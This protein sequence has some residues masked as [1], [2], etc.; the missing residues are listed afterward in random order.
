[1]SGYQL[2]DSGDGLKLEQFG[3]KLLVRPS[4]LC[5]WRPREDREIWGATDA[6][7]DHKTGW[8][9]HTKRFD[10]WE[11]EINDLAL[12]LRL[13]SNGQ[14]GLFPEHLFV[15]PILEKYLSQK[16]DSTVLNLY[17]YTG[18]ASLL[19]LRYGAQV[20]HVDI[21]KNVLTWAKKNQEAS[22]LH[23]YQLRLIP[24]DAVKFASREEKRGNGYDII[25]AD[26]PS[27]TRG[28]DSKG[29]LLEESLL[30]LIEILG[31][32]LNKG[33]TLIL[34]SHRH[35]LSAEILANLVYDGIP[36]IVSLEERNLVLHEKSSP[37]KIP[38]G[39][40]V[41]ATVA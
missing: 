30:P 8:S 6:S 7:Y 23:D 34:T 11:I 4:R 15:A 26:P 35:E 21:S 33:G 5:F 41:I 19:S 9:F 14:V 17:A 31:S 29:T 10:E 25:I 12:T 20:T 1:M 40:A 18:A 2:I 24:D 27:F 39:F 37:R 16:T 28:S 13:Q 32:L 22:G 38:A 3:S 36:D